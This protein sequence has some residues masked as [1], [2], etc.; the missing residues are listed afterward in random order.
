MGEEDQG[1]MRAG[2]GLV[3]DA[4]GALMLRWRR[5]VK[6]RHRWSWLS[7]NAWEGWMRGLFFAGA[8]VEAEVV[9]EGEA[10]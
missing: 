10:E 6:V 5:S 7:W 4:R 9:V 8:W 3:L 1:R 2:E